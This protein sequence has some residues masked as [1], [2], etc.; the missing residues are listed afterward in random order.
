MM[1]LHVF[2][3]ILV[4]ITAST[5]QTGGGP[6]GN[7]V[8]DAN[9]SASTNPVISNPA[10]TQTNPSNASPTPISNVPPIPNKIST[11]G[12]NQNSPNDKNNFSN[13]QLD[14]ALLYSSALANGSYFTNFYFTTSATSVATTSANIG[15]IISS[16][17]K[18]FTKCAK[19]TSN[20]ISNRSCSSLTSFQC[21]CQKPKFV[22]LV[23]KLP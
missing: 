22:D 20:S 6:A 21:D 8:G 2:F 1:L 17:P 11:K 16:L 7:S 18:C 10:T 12:Q 4:T 15:K 13:L 19:D 9:Q 5:C 3:I 23:S 14:D